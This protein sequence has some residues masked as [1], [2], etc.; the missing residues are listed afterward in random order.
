MSD[1]HSARPTWSIEAYVA[2]NEALREAEAKFQ[3]ERDR[4]YSEVA[5]E[6]EKALRIK[7]QADRDAL[8]LAR[9]I[10]VYKDEKANELREQINSERGLYITRTEMKPVFDFMASQSAKSDQ[11]RWLIGTAIALAGVVVVLIF[12]LLK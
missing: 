6:R 7:E 2:H 3:A 12:R 9:E 1:D 4:R 11:S 5:V 8:G 10:Q